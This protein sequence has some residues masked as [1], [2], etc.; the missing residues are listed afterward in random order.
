[1]TK[2]TAGQFAQAV[3]RLG[4]DPDWHTVL[5]YLD[6]QYEDLKEQLVSVDGANAET[7]RG[8]AQAFRQL[9]TEIRQARGTLESQEKNRRGAPPTGIL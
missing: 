1:M 5:G 4:G 7:L 3:V 8:R 9:R 2:I 6:A